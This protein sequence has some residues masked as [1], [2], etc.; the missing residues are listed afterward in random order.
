VDGWSGI[1]A[2]VLR[3]KPLVMFHIKNTFL[4]RTDQDRDQA[5]NPGSLDFGSNEPRIQL[6]FLL[7]LVYAVVTP[8]LLPFI[9]VFFSLAYLVFRH[10]V[11]I[12]PPVQ[13][14]LFTHI[15]SLPF[16]SVF[17]FYFFVVFLA[18]FWTSLKS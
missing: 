6:Y 16:S 7:G 18:Y 1:A 4:V 3:L 17:Y 10:Q 14:V 11:Q 9:I 5:M 8:I 13:V 15:I 2:E 12:C